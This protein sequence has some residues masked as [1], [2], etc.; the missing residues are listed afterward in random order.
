MTNIPSHVFLFA[1]D[2]RT[3][4]SGWQGAPYFR[5]YGRELDSK[6]EISLKKH[7]G[8]YR[9]TTLLGGLNTARNTVLRAEPGRHPPKNKE[10]RANIEVTI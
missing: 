1:K 10:R 6:Q 4:S 8:G 5:R 2:Y 9:T 3:V 7:W